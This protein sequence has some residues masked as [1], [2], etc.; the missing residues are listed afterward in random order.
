MDQPADFPSGKTLV[1]G[2]GNTL[3]GDDGVGPHVAT[4]AASW[5]LPGLQSLAVPQLTPELAEPVAAAELVIFVD[6]RRDDGKGTIEVSALAPSNSEGVFGH[7]GEPRT[8]LALA[9]SIFGSCPQA[10]LITIPAADFSLGEG[11]S[12]IAR[13][14]AEAALARIRRL[15][16]VDVGTEV[17]DAR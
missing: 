5:G 1:I 11:L 3:R 15:L 14:C 2:Y 10:W 13:Q 4:V 16:E 6:A 17:A 9:Q 12:S 7:V 8:L